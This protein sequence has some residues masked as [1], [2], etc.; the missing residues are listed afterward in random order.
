MDPRRWRNAPLAQRLFI[1]HNL[2]MRVG[3]RLVGDL[4]LTSS[5]WLL[6]GAIEQFEDPPTLSELSGNA[7]LSLQNVSR[8]VASMESD[9]L[10]ERFTLPGRGRA[11][12]VRMTQRGAEIHAAAEEAAKR[13][14]ES[15]LSGMDG[16]DISET[17][18]RLERMINNLEA[19]EAE[20][21]TESERD[22]K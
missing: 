12:F 1:V 20:L 15:F 21:N 10:V 11:T 3:D 2:M 16:T 22:G 8:M 6:L 5:R 7:L 9:G 18:N 4:G 14:S 19:F 13:F 17:E